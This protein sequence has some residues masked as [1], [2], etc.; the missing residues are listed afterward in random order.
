MLEKY[1]TI[2]TDAHGN[3]L[4]DTYMQ[5]F[6]RSIAAQLIYL[7]TMHPVTYVNMFAKINTKDILDHLLHDDVLLELI[8]DSGTDNG[9]D[10]GSDN[11]SDDSDSNTNSLKSKFMNY[12]EKLTWEF[13]LF[14]NIKTLLISSDNALQYSDFNF[15]SDDFKWTITANEKNEI[16]VKE[17]ADGVYRM[18]A[19]KYD[20]WCEYI[21]VLKLTEL[22]EGNLACEIVIDRS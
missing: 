17:F 12:L 15:T 19:L 14:T 1:V 4:C 5:E 2:T 10:D 6:L 9:S 3:F 20:D 21:S 8:D 18:K 7:V 22:S 11:G 13:P 16:T